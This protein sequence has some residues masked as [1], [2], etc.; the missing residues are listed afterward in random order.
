M[1]SE[2]LVMKE[3]TLGS[4]ILGFSM[5]FKDLSDTNLDWA[6]PLLSFLQFLCYCMGN[7]WNWQDLII[8]EQ[9]SGQVENFFFAIE[10]E[11]PDQIKWDFGFN[12]AQ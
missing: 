12:S 8:F 11:P 9:I 7:R 3:L 4:R 2:I 10:I 6:D 1:F 5:E